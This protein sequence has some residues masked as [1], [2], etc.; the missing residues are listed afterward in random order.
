MKLLVN[1]GGRGEQ[2]GNS[3]II[4]IMRSCKLRQ[5][6]K[7]ILQETNTYIYI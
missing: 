5:F 2:Q 4:I 1:C 3:S 6:T 7:S